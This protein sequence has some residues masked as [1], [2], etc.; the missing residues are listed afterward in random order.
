[1]PDSK[2]SQLVGALKLPDAIATIY[3]E[4]RNYSAPLRVSTKY[5]T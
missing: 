2:L 5:S 1:V 3:P 4:P